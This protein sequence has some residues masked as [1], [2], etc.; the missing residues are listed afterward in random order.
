VTGFK[1][2]PCCRVT[3][4]LHCRGHFSPPTYNTKTGHEPAA[5]CVFWLLLGGA[6]ATTEGMDPSFPSLQGHTFSVPRSPKGYT[7]SAPR[8]PT[9]PRG[10]YSQRPSLS[11]GVPRRRPW[12]E[13]DATTR[14]TINFGSTVWV[15]LVWCVAKQR[16]SYPRQEFMW[17][18]A[19]VLCSHKK[20]V[21]L[22]RRL[23]PIMA[24]LTTC[25]T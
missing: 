10:L 20:H 11:P 8:C 6:K 22:R 25:L 12:E 21:Q 17:H 5:F 2:F 23:R 18:D 1:E 3:A 19:G 16:I 7:C 15:A 24:R 4:A 13:P 9:F 14:H